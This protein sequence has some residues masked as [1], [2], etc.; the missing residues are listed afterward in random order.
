M[1]E[2][3][4]VARD[5][6]AD[7]EAFALT[8]YPSYNRGMFDEETQETPRPRNLAPNTGEE[9]IRE[10]DKFYT[11][12]EVAEACMDFVRHT[13]EAE[14]VTHVGTW[15]EPSAGAGAFL[16]L[17]P[18]GNRI[19]FDIAPAP[20][21]DDVV[22]QDFTRWKGLNSLP[23]PVVT[24]GNPPF[25]RNA[26]LALRFVNLLAGGR[27]GDYVCFILPRTFE[28]VA[29]QHKVGQSL[30]LVAEMK[31]ATN[32]FTHDGRDYPVPCCFQIW[33]HMGNEYQRDRQHR[34]IEHNDFDIVPGENGFAHLP[35]DEQP[36]FAFQ[37]VGGQAGMVSVEGLTKSW[38]SHYLIKPNI[39]CDV[40]F[41]RLKALEPKW[42]AI[43]ERTAG[44]PSIGKN[45]LVEAYQQYL[46]EHGIPASPGKKRLI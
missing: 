4:T 29:M 23:G 18:A 2:A 11:K 36:K 41:E 24:V 46:D 9:D 12:P 30:R 25:G 42:L 44:N 43:R 13:L 40:L 45:E 34:P 1:A 21:V 8:D 5:A 26:S 28:K 31:M 33:T 3:L 27:K 35:E 37:R 22:E 7:D 19:G 6:G 39:A 38:R 20:G 17:M 32:S 16:H 15:L 14:G 10:R